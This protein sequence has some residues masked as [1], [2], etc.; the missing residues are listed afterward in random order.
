MPA[1]LWALGSAFVLFLGFVHGGTEQP[2]TTAMTRFSH[3]L[4]PD[5]EIPRFFADWYFHHGN[6]GPPPPF[7]DWLSSD[8]PPLQVGYVLAQRP[9]GWDDP[10][11]HY[12]VLA[13]VVQQLWILAMWALLSP[14]ASA[15][16]PVAWRSSPPR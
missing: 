2:L 11:L 5:N 4:P 7:G 12:E 1:A 15:R 14:P 8:R 13:V 10:G 9:F 3:P 16:S 6:Q